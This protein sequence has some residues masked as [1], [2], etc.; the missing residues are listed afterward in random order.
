MNVR[1]TTESAASTGADTIVVG[2][3][4]GTLLG[5]YRFDRYRKAPEDE[6]AR[7]DELIVS[8]HEDRSQ[9]VAGAVIVAEAVNAAR[10]LQ[11]APA[12]DMTPA[13]LGERARELAS[14]FDGLEAEVEGRDEIVGRGM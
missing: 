9:V 1:A 7:I 11:N 6:P 8:D 13:R 4:E 10:D 2:L 5:D 12:N 3:V 14:Q